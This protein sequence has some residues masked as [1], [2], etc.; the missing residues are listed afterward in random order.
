[1][2][3]HGSCLHPRIPSPI[4]QPLIDYAP[5]PVS[6][7]AASIGGEEEGEAR[8]EDDGAPDEDESKGGSPDAGNQEDAAPKDVAPGEDAG[9]R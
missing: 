9:D 8:A 5:F 2:L 4:V 1:M 7:G 6:R 3:S